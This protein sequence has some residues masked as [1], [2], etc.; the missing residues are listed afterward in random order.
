MRAAYIERLGGADEIVVG[1]LPTPQ[2]GEYEV[3]VRV[4]ASAVDSVDLFVRSG[5]YTTPTPFPF[6]I[7]RDL[8]GVADAVGPAVEGFAPGDRVW[9]NSLGHGG[10][11]GAASEC[12]VVAANRLY[13]L[14]DGVDPVRA[15]SVLHPAATAH[16]ALFAHGR[17]R[18]GETVAL[19]GGAGHVGA[20]AVAMASEAG[21]RVVAT[22]SASDRD[23]VLAAGA[24]VALDYRADDVPRQLRDAA[25]GGYD[26]W[27][28]TAGRQDLRLAVDLLAKGG[29]IIAIAGIT[30]EPVLPLG[31]LYTRD[32]SILGFAIS[33]ASVADLAE[34]AE[35][36]NR[37][38]ASGTLPERTVRTLPLDQAAQ[39]HRDLESGAARGQRLVLLP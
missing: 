2:P 15:V 9:C 39:A 34:A 7:G 21:L 38:L 1:E 8:V 3:L 4:E 29:R 6:V 33:N 16:L 14:P 24:S 30:A 26:L 36:V 27:L 32:G 12:A 37:L 10:R 20:M 17:G 25:P 23:A 11:Q 13:R 19:L 28:D 18:A 5:A 22:C 31:Q 35:H